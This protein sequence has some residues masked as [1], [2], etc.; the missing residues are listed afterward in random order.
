MGVPTS[1][2][3]NEIFSGSCQESGFQ[4]FERK[5]A[6][7]QWKKLSSTVIFVIKEGGF[8][9]APSL[10]SNSGSFGSS[11]FPLIIRFSLML[12]MK[13]INP[14]FGF[15]IIFLCP[16]ISLLP[17]LSG[18]NNVF[19]SCT[20]TNPGASPSGEQVMNPLPLAVD[21]TIKGDLFL[22]LPDVPLHITL[23]IALD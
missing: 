23:A 22:P 13:K 11:A 15:S 18:M 2:F 16:A 7:P 12:D 9:R 1:I 4:R 5:R 3:P 6:F 10:L 20:Q 14:I 19:W 21:K 17:G 8:P